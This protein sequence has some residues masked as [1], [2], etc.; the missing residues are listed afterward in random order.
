MDFIYLFLFYRI[1][2]D[3]KTE[4]TLRA[5]MEA[6]RDEAREVLAF[7]LH[8]GAPLD[9]TVAATLHGFHAR[10]VDLVAS[11]DAGL[12]CV[13]HLRADPLF[14]LQFMVKKL[15]NYFIVKEFLMPLLKGILCVRNQLQLTEIAVSSLFCFSGV[16]SRS[17]RRWPPHLRPTPP[18]WPPSPWR[19]RRKRRRR[20]EA[21]GP[22]VFGP[23][24]SRYDKSNLSS[25][26]P[27]QP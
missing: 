25:D 19:R 11:L 1:P 13:A 15:L 24:R 20:P 2:S 7:L 12:T 23:R 17:W 9:P 10:L 22:G 21:R 27:L 26:R 5:G 3:Y 6:T 4:G 8:M 14:G 16:S 18:R